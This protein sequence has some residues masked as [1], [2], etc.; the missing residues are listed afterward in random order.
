MPKNIRDFMP[1]GTVMSGVSTATDLINRIKEFPKTAVGHRQYTVQFKIDVV[2]FRRKYRMPATVVGKTLDIHPEQIRQWDVAYSTGRLTVQNAVAV[3]RISDTRDEPVDL[4]RKI[5][6]QF[7]QLARNIEEAQQ[8]LELAK[9]ELA[10]CENAY[11][12][13]E[14]KVKATCSAVG[15]DPK[16]LYQPKN[17]EAA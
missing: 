17:G 8:A 4:D 9:E 1:P 14:D 2:E 11:A 10:A 3:S 7:T 13:F 16:A 15:F 12:E 5:R 6:R